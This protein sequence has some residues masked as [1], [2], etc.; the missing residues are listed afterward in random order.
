MHLRICTGLLL[1]LSKS[2]KINKVIK[3]IQISEAAEVKPCTCGQH[4]KSDQ[5]S[6]K[7]LGRSRNRKLRIKINDAIKVIKVI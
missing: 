5:M 1:R 2:L 6:S 4:H 3:V 7:S